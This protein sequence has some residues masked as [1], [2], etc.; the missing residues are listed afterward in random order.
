M[1]S[2]KIHLTESCTYKGFFQILR[3]DFNEV[4]ALVASLETIRVM[5]LMHQLVKST[6][7][8]GQL[9]EEFY[10]KYPSGFDIKE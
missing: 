8:N 10:V 1:T 6:F 7:L 5:V 9:K 4:Y 2:Y 3:I